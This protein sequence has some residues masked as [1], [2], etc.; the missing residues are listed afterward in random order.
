MHKKDRKI[1]AI[2]TISVV[3]ALATVSWSGA[4]TARDAQPSQPTLAS[5]SSGSVQDALGPEVVAAANIANANK[6]AR[7]N[8]TAVVVTAGP[9]D[10]VIRLTQRAC[11]KSHGWNLVATANNITAASGY[12][13]LTGQQLTVDCVAAASA[14]ADVYPVSQPV[15]RQTS[16]QQQPAPAPQP[17]QQ[18][19]VNGNWTQPL[20]G[21]CYT[22]SFGWRNGRIHQG[23]DFPTA[24][25]TP[26]R[27]AGGGTVSWGNDPDGA[28]WYI[29]IDHGGNLFT[30]YYHLSERWA[31][32]GQWV[33]V[34]DVIGKSG[35]ARGAAGAGNSS[36]PHLHFEVHPWGKWTKHWNDAL[37]ANTYQNPVQWLGWVGAPVY[38][39]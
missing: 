2:A 16:T 22:S 21:K 38:H 29:V 33:N 15:Q 6:V 30:T 39:C 27:A 7:E 25:G 8:A 28:G 37:G 18:P 20:A 4:A 36:G 32:P 13:V 31:Q 11:G 10:G 9:N 24:V 34:G 12:L 14:P 35:G 23:A 5:L 3:A 17:Q 1:V 19:A 26:V